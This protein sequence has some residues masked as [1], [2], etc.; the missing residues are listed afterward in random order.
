VITKEAVIMFFHR[1]TTDFEVSKL[2]VVKVLSQHEK[3]CKVF[4]LSQ[5]LASV[6]SDIPTREFSSAVECLEKLVRSWEQ[7][8]HVKVEVVEESCLDTD[9]GH[10]QND[11]KSM[12]CICPRQAIEYT[13]PLEL[14]SASLGKKMGKP[15]LHWGMQ[16]LSSKEASVSL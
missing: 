12:Y 14:L 3:Y 6:A 13:S 4:D 5:R 10:Q 7:G 1:L 11:D 2:P 16:N 15:G 8:K 9:F